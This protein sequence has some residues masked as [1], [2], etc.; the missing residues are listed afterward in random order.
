MA[1]EQQMIQC[2]SIGAD[3]IR[4]IFTVHGTSASITIQLDDLDRYRM[5]ATFSLENLE[6]VIAMAKNNIKD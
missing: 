1:I 4:G 3:E 6:R 5:K 2:K